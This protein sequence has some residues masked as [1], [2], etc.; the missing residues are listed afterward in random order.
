[1]HINEMRADLDGQFPAL[2]CMCAISSSNQSMT[3]PTFHVA[4]NLDTFFRFFANPARL[5]LPHP[6]WKI[7]DRWTDQPLPVGSATQRVSHGFLQ[8]TLAQ[9]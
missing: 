9:Q 6:A 3:N 8:D 1:M 5:R 2:L 7:K 4:T